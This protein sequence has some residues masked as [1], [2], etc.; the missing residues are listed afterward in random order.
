MFRSKRRIKC[1]SKFRPSTV[2]VN[3]SR[4]CCEF[5][6]WICLDLRRHELW[7]F[8]ASVDIKDQ[9]SWSSIKYFHDENS[10]SG[11]ID[12]TCF[13]NSIPL[14]LVSKRLKDA[15]FSRGSCG[16][17]R[18]DGALPSRRR[19]FRPRSRSRKPRSEATSLECVYIY[20]QNIKSILQ[21]SSTK[22]G[23]L[24]PEWIHWNGDWWA[25]WW[26]IRSASTDGWLEYTLKEE[27]LWWFGRLTKELSENDIS[28][29]IFKMP[30]GSFQNVN[31][32]K[33]K[34]RHQT[35]LPRSKK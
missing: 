4:L 26:Q 18:S 20:R 6:G 5:H 30:P 19:S 9:I 25:I 23:L 8:P 7:S 32:S 15:N 34:N 14:G 21:I 3:S 22:L 33:F 28:L 12:W 17:S 31:C 27:N 35:L 10:G 1:C 29:K 24:I 2:P 11:K 16:H 13:R